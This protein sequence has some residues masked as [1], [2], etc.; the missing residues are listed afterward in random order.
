MKPIHQSMAMFLVLLLLMNLL[1]LSAFA[2]EAPAAEL[3][4]EEITEE[5]P[6]EELSPTPEPTP[7]PT[8]SP[9]PTPTPTETPA[10]EPTEAPAEE[11]PMLTPEPEAETASGPNLEEVQAVLDSLPEL[12]AVMDMGPDEQMEV[13]QQFSDACDLFY[14]LSMEAQEII[15]MTRMFELSAF[16]ASPEMAATQYYQETWDT[17]DLTTYTQ[18]SWYDANGYYR[19]WAL[20]LINNHWI[21]DTSAGHAAYCIRPD[22]GETNYYYYYT[23]GTGSSAWDSQITSAQ[24]YLIR[25]ALL[26]GY[27]NCVNTPGHVH[28]ASYCQSATQMIIFEAITKRLNTYAPYT[29]SDTIFCD[30]LPYS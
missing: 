27:P 9:E 2:E 19:A 4:S 11:T 23:S 7:T 17:N 28:N 30:A 6:A 29:H 26:Y 3:V 12:N 16:F 25:L 21:Y 5:I 13:Y 14:M 8:E 24:R 20:G 1:P 18:G 22:R 10:P 15:D